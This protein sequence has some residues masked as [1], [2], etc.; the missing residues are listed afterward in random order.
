M[1]GSSVIAIAKK[2]FLDHIRSRKFLLIFGILLIVSVVGILNGVSDYNTSV[3]SYNN[4]QHS[5]SGSGGPVSPVDLY[6]KQKPSVLLVFYQIGV[7]FELIGGI[8]G[9]AMGFDLITKEKESKSLKILLAHP[10]YR[11][12]VINGKTLGGIAAIILTLG[13]TMAVSLAILLLFGIVP[14]LSELLPILVF[15]AATF[16]LIFSFFAIAILMSTLCEESGRSLVYTLIIFVTLGSFIPALIMS[17]LVME[18]VIGQAPEMPM[19]TAYPTEKLA[20]PADH[21]AETE[22]IQ[23][24]NREARERYGQQNQEYKERA[25]ILADAQYLVS[26]T[27][28]YG[29]ITTFLT[30]PM[31]MS[32]MLYG[33]TGAGTSGDMNKDDKEILVTYKSRKI[34]DLDLYSVLAMLAKNFTALLVLPAVFFGLA[35]VSFMRMDIR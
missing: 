9:I 30:N 1:M 17:P 26:P 19:M 31:G 33:L 2:E 34:I 3:T 5:V 21:A 6:M 23:K 32:E 22:R 16:L 20:N 13:C 15:Y 24:E 10:V 11:D 18:M 35:Y 7:M 12:Q 14:G 8:L 25:T 27:N 28:N 4:L 29:K